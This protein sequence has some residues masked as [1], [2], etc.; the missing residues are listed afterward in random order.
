MDDKPLIVQS[1]ATLMLDAHSSLFDQARANIAVFAELEKSPEH[2]HLYRISPL[3][4]WNAAASGVSL[5]SISQTL[6][7]H[8]RYPIPPSILFQI[9]ENYKRYG[10]LEL[11]ETAN[12]NTSLLLACAPDDGALY[13]EIAAQRRLAKYLTPVKEGFLLNRLNRG[14]LKQE[15]LKLGWPAKDL[16]PLAQGAPLEV[17]LCPDV[18]VRDYQKDAL[19]AFIGRYLPGSGFGV[20]VLPCGAGKT[21][22]GLAA[23]AQL[24][25]ETLILAANIAAGRQWIREILEKTNLSPSLIGEYSGERKEIKPIT[26]ATYQILVWRKDKE[27]EFEH[28]KLFHKRHWGLVIYDEAHLLPAPV[29][30]VTGEIQSVRRLGLTATLVREDGAEGDVFSLIGPKRFDVP[31]RDLE[32]AGWIAQ[33]YCIEVKCDLTAQEQLK[34]AVAP[35]RAKVRIAAESEAKVRIAQ[36]IAQM[37]WGEP[38][39]VIGQYLSQLH[40]LAEAFEA[41]LITGKT[42]NNERERIYNAFRNGEI[43]L[44]IVSK[45]ANF[46]IDLPDASIAIQVSG[47]FGSRQEEAQRLGRIL[48]PKERC[49]YF[50]SLVSRFTD[51]ELFSANRQKFLAEQGY[52]YQ[53]CEESDF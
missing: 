23:I 14:T 39:L 53:I 13:Q 22:V 29:F 11:R 20:V 12:D 47:S 19:S 1:D 45:V 15:L 52:A 7:K 37:R 46:S 31:W 16:A 51:E 38:I 50:Y 27:S 2:F 48:R 21:I 36:K 35:K 44:L 49:S 33:A 42:P 40:K 30:R 41:P 17:E 28:F 26:V 6:Q 3:S 18:V 43:P 34:Y 5:A 25:T 10:R 8:S 32:R 9:S 4:I 24:K